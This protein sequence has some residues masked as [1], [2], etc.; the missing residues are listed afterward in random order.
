MSIHAPVDR[1][2]AVPLGRWLLGQRGREDLIGQLADAARRDPGFPTDG[3]FEAISKRLN[4]VGA[5]PDMHEALDQA[6]LDWAA[7]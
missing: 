6:E 2:T 3:D 5:D 4:I 7:Y 1:A